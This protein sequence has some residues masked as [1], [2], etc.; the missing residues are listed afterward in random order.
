MP[1]FFDLQPI[2]RRWLVAVLEFSQSFCMLSPIWWQHQQVCCFNPRSACF[3][4]RSLYFFQ[5]LLK[6]STKLW[7]LAIARWTRSS[8]RDLLMARSRLCPKQLSLG[9]SRSWNAKTKFKPLSV[10]VTT[11]LSSFSSQLARM[12]WRSLARFWPVWSSNR[13]TVSRQ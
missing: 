5:L 8:C 11:S 9:Y 10:A 4:W 3:W 12:P 1:I 2:Q 13:G 6:A 7:H